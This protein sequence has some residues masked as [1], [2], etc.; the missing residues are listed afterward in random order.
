MIYIFDNCFF[1]YFW[2]ILI[3]RYAFKE[4]T[5]PWMIHAISKSKMSYYYKYKRLKA[6]EI[7]TIMV[8]RSIS[9][10]G[11]GKIYCLQ[12]QSE[13]VGRQ[14]SEKDK[15]RQRRG[16]CLKHL[17][18]SERCRKEQRSSRGNRKQSNM[19]MDIRV[20]FSCFNW[21]KWNWI[22]SWTCLHLR[23]WLCWG[24]GTIH[25][26]SFFFIFFSSLSN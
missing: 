5:L 20:L 10:I 8:Q 19:C 24:L 17:F 1:I 23:I 22:E 21:W 13:N 11:V 4:K 14:R 9:L 3:L 18:R 26:F 7:W 15:H 25:C 12:W 6:L 2:I 16:A